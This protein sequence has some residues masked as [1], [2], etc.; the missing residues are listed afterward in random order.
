MSDLV[1]GPGVVTRPRVDSQRPGFVPDPIMFLSL[2]E[3]WPCHSSSQHSLPPGGKIRN[4]EKWGK[5]CHGSSA[6]WEMSWYVR[7][8]CNFA[9][10]ETEV[11]I[12]TSSVGVGCDARAV[13]E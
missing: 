6:R 11:G 10:D 2:L 12:V 9:S 5:S 1:R 7:P 4:F 13:S 3:K 8:R